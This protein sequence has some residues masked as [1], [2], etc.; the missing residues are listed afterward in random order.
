MRRCALPRSCPPICAWKDAQTLD[1]KTFIETNARWLGGGFILVFASSFGQTFFISLFGGEIRAAFDLT[2]G[3]FG[4]IYAIGTLASAATLIWLG[5]FADEMRVAHL[6]ALVLIGLSV[7]CLTMSF[8]GSVVLLCLAIY[9]LRL[10]GQGMLL[11]IS[12]TAM[13][14]WFSAHR[15]RAVGV[16]GLGLPL[17]EALLPF[18]TILL[19]S[20]IGW[21]EVWV[22]GAIFLLVAIL[23][24][25]WV[26]FQISRTPSGEVGTPMARTDNVHAPRDWTR[27]EVLRDPVFYGLLPGLL[28]PAFITTGI[29]FHQVHLM[30]EKAWDITTMPAV[31]PFFAAASVLSAL[32]SGWLIDRWNAVVFLPLFLLPLALAVVLIAL[33]PS[34][35]VAPVFMLLSGITVGM[36]KTI[37]G[38]LWPELY[39]VRHLGA[40][41]SVTMALAVFATALSPWTVGLMADIGVTMAA[42]MLAMGAYTLVVSGILWHVMRV[43]QAARTGAISGPTDTIGSA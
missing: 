41:R 35:I 2:H 4:S 8:A 34:A 40:I 26:L 32:V 17:G 30:D 10:M 9:L 16:V 7:A 18:V 38:A 3:G 21:R 20:A 33:V 37:S 24:A 25:T 31:F 11:H 15:G 22:G 5:K 42:Q 36:M 43:I 28:A 6:S 19:I 39:G 1:Y 29:F 27:A 12:M 13:G 23:P 14:R